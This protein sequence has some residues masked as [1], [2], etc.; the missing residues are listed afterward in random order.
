MKTTEVSCELAANKATPDMEVPK[1][2]T[3]QAGLDGS[4]GKNAVL[5]LQTRCKPV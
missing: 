2:T 3:Y 5:V 1:R 4:A